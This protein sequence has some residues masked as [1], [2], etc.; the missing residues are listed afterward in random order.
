MKKIL[1]NKRGGGNLL[2]S[3]ISAIMSII[4]ILAFLRMLGIEIDFAGYIREGVN[5]FIE[6]VNDL[7]NAF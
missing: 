2:T 5:A 7:K 3:I 6:L 4:I 1:G